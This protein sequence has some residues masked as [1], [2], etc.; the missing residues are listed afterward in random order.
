MPASYFDTN[1]SFTMATET[2]TETS[3]SEVTL[4]SP[5]ERCEAF[6]HGQVREVYFVENRSDVMTALNRLWTG[7]QET[8]IMVVGGVALT[9]GVVVVG[10]LGLAAGT[11]VFGLA[12]ASEAVSLASSCCA[13]L[14]E[15]VSE[16]IKLLAD[17]CRW[18][19]EKT[20][21]FAKIVGLGG[22]AVAMTLVK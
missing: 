5:V 16:V 10:S 11:L 1:Q 12:G 9:V 13:M 3:A 20:E 6:K 14:I 15:K 22:M 19:A 7:A 8:V 21:K 2:Q 17:G 18:V 4:E